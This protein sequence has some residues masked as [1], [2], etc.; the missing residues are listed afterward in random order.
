MLFSVFTYSSNG[1]EIED[2][3]AVLPGVGVT[4]LLLALVV[5]AVHLRDLSRLVVST[6]KSDL[7]GP[8]SLERKEVCEGLQR[9]VSAIDEIAH[10]NV[11]GVRQGTSSLEQLAQIVELSMNVSANSDR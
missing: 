6:Q 10:K 7:I 1:Q 4:V 3:S 9:V 2:L 5:E 11:V 8:A